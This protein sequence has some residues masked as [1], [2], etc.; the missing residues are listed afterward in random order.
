MQRVNVLCADKL[1]SPST[2]IWIL[3]FHMEDNESFNETV[4]TGFSI[5]HSAIKHSVLQPCLQALSVQHHMSLILFTREKRRLQKTQTT[6]LC[7]YSISRLYFKNK[8]INV[9]RRYHSIKV[10]SWGLLNRWPVGA[11]QHP[12]LC[13]KWVTRPL[14]HPYMHPGVPPCASCSCCYR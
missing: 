3:S 14:W 2:T 6:F 9:C 11:S 13:Y 8:E 7:W 12:Q 1:E 5:E 4:R 10:W